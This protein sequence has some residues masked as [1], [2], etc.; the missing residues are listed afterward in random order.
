MNIQNW[1]EEVKCSFHSIAEMQRLLANMSAQN[2]HKHELSDVEFR[3]FDKLFRPEEGAH[4]LAYHV[5]VDELIK[6]INQ[7]VL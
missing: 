5:L 1:Y 3:E 4:Q 6:L 2:Y 7:P